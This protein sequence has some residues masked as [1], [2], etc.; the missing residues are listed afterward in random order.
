MPGYGNISPATTG[1][2]VF[3]VFFAIIGIPLFLVVAGAIGEKLKSASQKLE[4][5]MQCKSLKDR[6]KALKSLSTLLVTVMGL[7]YCTIDKVNNYH[8]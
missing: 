1:G 2:R 6:P 7:V 8:L 4:E 5:K 3:C